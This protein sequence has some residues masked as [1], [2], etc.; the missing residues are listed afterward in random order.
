LE[1]NNAQ[2][3][4]WIAE[5]AQDQARTQTNILALNAAVEAARAGEAGAGFAVVAD[6]VRALAQRSAQS[7]R[8]TTELIATSKTNAAAGAKASERLGALMKAIEADTAKVV[9]QV[10]HIANVSHEQSQGVGQINTAVIQMDK[11]TQSNAS[12]A[13]ETASASEELSAQA[14][15]LRGTVRALQ[16]IVSKSKDDATQGATDDRHFIH[17]ESTEPEKPAPKNAPPKAK[18]PTRGKKTAGD[19]FWSS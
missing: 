10:A 8:E 14:E 4:A 1:N 19:E 7:A 17:H 9:E 12:S 15:E 2:I 6:E 13:E 11:V 16:S 5:L 3:D 18:E